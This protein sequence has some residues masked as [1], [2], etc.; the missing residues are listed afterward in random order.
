MG[1][2]TVFGTVGCRFESCLACETSADVDSAH[3]LSVVE[4]SKNGLSYGVMW[5][6]PARFLVGC[7]SALGG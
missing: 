2:T 4:G 7:G 1:S 3:G 6:F 5:M